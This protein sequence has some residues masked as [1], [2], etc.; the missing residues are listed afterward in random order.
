MGPWIRSYLLRE[1]NFLKSVSQPCQPEDV[2]TSAPRIQSFKAQP[3]F[4][5]Y[6]EGE[7]GQLCF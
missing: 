1:L 4:I 3:S 2:W 5:L 7:M 6:Y